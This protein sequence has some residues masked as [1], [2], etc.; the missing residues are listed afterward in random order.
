MTRDTK[1]A[2]LT[3]EECHRIWRWEGLMIGYYA[4]AMVLIVLSMLLLSVVPESSLARGAVIGLILLLI[5]VGYVVQFRERCPR[6][7]TKLGRQARVL[8]P[9]KCKSCGVVFPRRQDGTDPLE[10]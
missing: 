4:T 1:P 9:L 7:R 3:A 10:T 6:C 2:P 5:V 8:L